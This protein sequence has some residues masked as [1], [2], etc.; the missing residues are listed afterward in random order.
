[1]YLR[2]NS[3]SNYYVLNIVDEPAIKENFVH[4][5]TALLIF[6]YAEQLNTRELT[7]LNALT[8]LVGVSLGGKLII[9]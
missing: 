6:N 7:P 4:S 3:K 8:T 2:Y 9:I 5:D 1:M